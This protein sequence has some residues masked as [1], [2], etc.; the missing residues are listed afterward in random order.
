MIDLMLGNTN[1]YD[2]LWNHSELAKVGCLK[3]TEEKSRSQTSY[4]PAFN[5]RSA[6]IGKLL[7][8]A[9]AA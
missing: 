5:F 8:T 6:K 7:T 2:T 1:Q 3:L 9:G 4:K